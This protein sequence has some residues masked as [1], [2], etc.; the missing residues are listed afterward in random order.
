MENNP[1]IARPK[2]RYG[3]ILAKFIGSLYED[4]EIVASQLD[5]SDKNRV[6]KR[7]TIEECLTLTKQIN[8]FTLDLLN[9]SEYHIAKKYHLNTKKRL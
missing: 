7:L 4:T 6:R 9:L 3:E 8:I 5:K 1:L 2:L